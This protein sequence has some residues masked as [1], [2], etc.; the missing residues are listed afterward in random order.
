MP[1]R[2]GAWKRFGSVAVTQFQR[3][4][5]RKAANWR[6]RV[7]ALGGEILPALLLEDPAVELVVPED[8][9]GLALGVVVGAGEADE[10]GLR[11]ALSDSTT[12]STSQRRE[13]T[14][15]SSPVVGMLRKRGTTRERTLHRCASETMLESAPLP[16]K[17][18]GR[19]TWTT[20][21]LVVGPELDSEKGLLSISCYRPP[22][23]SY[24]SQAIDRHRFFGSATGS[25]L[26]SREPSPAR[27]PVDRILAQTQIRGYLG[28][29]HEVIHL[30]CRLIIFRNQ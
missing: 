19:P 12:S 29:C 16:S 3:S 13:R 10:G 21:S 28:Q 18:Q 15:T 6:G 25:D 17:L 26:G 24:A 23:Y 7:E 14:W 20:L 4:V 1:A 27:H 5:W 22:G 30:D 9:E 11:R 8:V 2:N